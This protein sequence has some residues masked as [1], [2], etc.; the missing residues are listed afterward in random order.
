SYAMT[1]DRISGL[2]IASPLKPVSKT[3]DLSPG[4]KESFCLQDSTVHYHEAIVKAALVCL[5][6]AWPRAISFEALCQ[7][8]RE[9]LGGGD[10]GADRRELGRH[11]LR[12]YGLAGARLVELWRCYPRFATHV[13]EW[14]VASPVARLMAEEGHP[15]PT[16]RHRCIPLSDLDRHLLTRLD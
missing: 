16:M 2:L 15:A 11:L 9:R 10:A 14:P 1:P 13:S 6:E 7:Q 12:L 5:A 3:T 8:A 4:R